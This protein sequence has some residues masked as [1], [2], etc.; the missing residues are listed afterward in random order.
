MPYSRSPSDPTRFPI[1]NR[2][3]SATPLCADRDP[4]LGRNALNPNA[5]TSSAAHHGRGQNVLFKDGSVKFLTTP[6]CEPA[7]DNIYPGSP[8]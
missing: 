1:G 2:T 6:A 7:N 5:G 4:H 8:K 3:D